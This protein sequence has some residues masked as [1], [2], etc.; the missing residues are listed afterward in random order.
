MGILRGFTLSALLL[1][2]PL[3]AG[4]D[5]ENV[6]HTLV[7][8]IRALSVGDLVTAR[9]LCTADYKVLEN[10]EIWDLER[11]LSSAKAL[12]DTGRR[13][14]DSVEFKQ[15]KIIGNSAYTVYLL[16]SDIEKS[17]IITRKRWLES[18]VFERNG[19]GW[20]ISLVHSTE[21]PNQAAGK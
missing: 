21:L 15:T 13:R 18:A 12:A 7:N 11:D 19:P 8:S 3:L 4:D 17:G 2:P 5:L 10:G 14:T 9:T 1:M 6:Q 16:V 20:R